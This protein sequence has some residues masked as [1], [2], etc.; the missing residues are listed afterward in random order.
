M[1]LS[2]CA[3]LW[4]YRDAGYG[5]VGISRIGRDRLLAKICAVLLVASAASLSFFSA[6]I[7]ASGASPLGPGPVAAAFLCSMIGAFVALVGL[8]V[9][10]VRLR[11]IDKHGL[12][13]SLLEERFDSPGMLQMNGPFVRSTNAVLKLVSGRGDFV[14]AAGAL[15]IPSTASHVCL[16]AA[17][18]VL[19]VGGVGLVR[20]MLSS[21]GGSVVVLSDDRTHFS[22]ADID[23]IT[24]RLNVSS[25]NVANVKISKGGAAV[26]PFGISPL[27]P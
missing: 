24:D 15:F 9:F 10:C 19:I 1:S 27:L 23:D 20:Y 26:V 6:Y 16:A 7:S 8:I 21:P 12:V 14:R 2:E 11:T 4:V 3:G 5:D 13:V 22:D 25:A 17:A 18:L